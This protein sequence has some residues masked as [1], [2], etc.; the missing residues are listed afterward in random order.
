MKDQLQLKN[1]SGQLAE[2][3]S[4][5]SDASFSGRSTALRWGSTPAPTSCWWQVHLC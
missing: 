4:G 3:M 1:R 2:R 5:Q